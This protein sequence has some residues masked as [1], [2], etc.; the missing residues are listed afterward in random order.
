MVAEGSHGREEKGELMM[1]VYQ[2]PR[3]DLR[4]AVYEVHSKNGDFKCVG[5]KIIFTEDIS[6]RTDGFHLITKLWS[7]GSL[8]VLSSDMIDEIRFLDYEKLEADRF[9]RPPGLI[10]GHSI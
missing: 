6:G 10:Y 4:A 2:T 1:E 8:L 9:K 7:D 5:L 3:D